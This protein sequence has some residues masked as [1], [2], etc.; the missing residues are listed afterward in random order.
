MAVSLLVVV[1]VASAASG[2]LGVESGAGF[3][4]ATLEDVPGG[5]SEARSSLSDSW[6]SES[7]A[8]MDDEG[9]PA[10]PDVAETPEIAPP[11]DAPEPISTAD[12]LFPVAGS[13]T[14]TDSFGDPRGG[15]SR[16]HEGVDILADKGTPVVAV[17]D[18]VVRWVHDEAGGRCCDVSVLHDNGW[19]TRY[20]HL[21]NDTPGT[22]DGRVVGIADGIRPGTRVQQGQVL[23]WVGDSGNAEATV[24]HLHFELRLA[25]GTPLDPFRRLQIASFPEETEDR[26]ARR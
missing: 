23:G 21:N 4:E 2:P 24:S 10:D 18:G 13:H 16:S 22:D 11:G 1:T 12:L 20:I 5:P 19:R 7:S 17:A 15:G 6:V 26:V 9:L 8:S 25:D 14:L 3:A